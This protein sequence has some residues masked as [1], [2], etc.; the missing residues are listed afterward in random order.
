[1]VESTLAPADMAPAAI[2][3]MPGVRDWSLAIRIAF[4]F[5]FVYFS[6]YVLTTQMLGGLI[7]IPGIGF[8]DLEQLRPVRSAYTWTALHLFHVTQPL[9]VAS[10]SGDKTFHWVGA[11]CLLVFAAAAALVWSV[12]DRRRRHYRSLNKWFRVFLR[13]AL[14]TTM[15]TYGMAKA[16]PLQMPYPTLSRLLEPYG[17][18]SPMGVLWY[19][20][21]AAPAYER[22]AGSMELTAAVL[23]FVPALPTLGAAVAF[24]DTVQ[25]LM[26]NL[27]YD[28]PGA[29]KALSLTHGADT[30]PAGR[31][32]YELRDATRLELDGQL[33][34][35][36]VR[37]ELRL[38]DTRNFLLLTRGFHWIQEYP[39]NQ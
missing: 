17:H 12:L 37:A 5:L 23:L 39:F 15:L 32:S 26:L 20:I 35:H 6:L 36:H 9:V 4:R 2:A 28:V 27:T 16:F 13:F 7:A 22:F 24:A 3:A 1:M 19:S 21:G 11:F 34:G 33:D 10:G 8:P 38:F 14:G 29:H 30:S 18:F 25:I 31:F